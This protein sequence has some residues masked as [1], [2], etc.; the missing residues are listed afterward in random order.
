[1]LWTKGHVKVQNLDFQLL[2]W[3]LTKFF[4]LFFKQRVGF[5]LNF[6]FCILLN[7][8]SWNIDD[9]DKKSPSKYNFS[10]F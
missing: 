5:L 10:D 8:S 9:L 6:A 1:M 7:F 4:M 2:A 3:K